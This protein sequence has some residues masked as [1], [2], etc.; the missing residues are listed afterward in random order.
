HKE[1]NFSYPY[2][3]AEFVE[4]LQSIPDY[5][6]KQLLDLRNGR[7]IKAKTGQVLNKEYRKNRA[8]FVLKLPID[9]L[10]EPKADARRLS[11]PAGTKILGEYDGV[12]GLT[13]MRHLDMEDNFWVAI[14]SEKES[15]ILG[16]ISGYGT[17]N[18]LPVRF[19]GLTE[20]N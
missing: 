14:V 2:I 17:F 13:L 16:W 12:E 18:Q 19:I 10:K 6:Q 4:E 3:N 5:L 15:K 9:V 11:V 20:F 7:P 1:Y 8:I